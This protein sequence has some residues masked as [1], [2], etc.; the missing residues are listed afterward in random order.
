MNRTPETASSTKRLGK[1]KKDSMRFQQSDI[2]KEE[3]FT[4]FKQGNETQELIGPILP[5]PMYMGFT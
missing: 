1:H 4:V 2:L 3:W 5:L